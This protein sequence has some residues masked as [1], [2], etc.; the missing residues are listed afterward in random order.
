VLL[1]DDLQWA[2][3]ATLELVPILASA[4]AQER[5]LI[6]GTYRNDEIGRGH[7][8]R[9][10]R[11]DLRRARLL[12]EIVV[13]PLDQAHTTALATRVFG[14]SPGP[15]LAS[16]LYQRTEGVPL[17]VKELAGALAI[18]GRLRLSEAG[19]ELVP[20]ADL[21]IP[22]TLRD[23]VLLR[24]DGLPDPAL[25]LLHLAVVAGREFD[26]ALVAELAGSTDG[27]DTLL[28]RGLLVEVE[29]GRGAFRHA[30]TREAIYGDISWVRRRAIHR[31]MAERLQ[32]EGVAPLA[33]AQH[34]LAAKEP[35]RA[36]TALL[37][38]A[39]QACAI[40]A[41]RDAADAAQRALELWPDG[42]E[43][44]RRL[45]VLDQ[46]G[47]CAQLC[48]MLPEAARVWREVADGR[49]L[50]G[51]LQSYAEAERKLANVAE[52]QGH[53]E[54]AL[55]AREA[56]AQA[57]AASK[58]PA[59]SATERLSAAAHLRSAGRYR[60]A[61]ELLST[62]MEEAA[63]AERLDLHARI[64][65]QE[66]SVRA[67]MGQAAEGLA[68]VQSG[69]ALA[70]ELNLASAAAEIYQRLAD[71]LEHAGDYAG[72]KE[73][74]L[75]AFDFCQANAVPTTAQ[76]CVAC[77]TVVLR[78]TGEWERA[79]TLCREVLASQHSSLHARAVASC[80]L[81]TLYALRG[82]PGRAQ[83]LLLEAAS[84]GQQ[85]ELAAVELLAAWGLA[86]LDELNG[87]SGT[88]AERCRFI[89][90]RW[91]QIEDI[92]YAVPVLRWAVSFFAT[93]NAD[94]DA[95]A[96]ANA[97]ARIASATGQPE[98]LSALAHALGEIALLDG[99]PQQA[100]QQF[101]QAL[102]LLRDVAIPYC[103]ANTQWRAGIACAAANQRDAAVAHLANAYRTAR[104]L[105]ARPLATRIAQA[106]AALGEPIVEH[107]GPGAAGRFR[108][109]DL[110]RR[111]R[112]ILQ[113]VAQ[114]QTNVEIARTLVLSPRT[115]EMHVANIL[116][117]LD[118]RSRAEAVRRATELSL[119]EEYDMTSKKIL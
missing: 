12:H 118:S 58:L 38:A 105:G 81:G 87:A 101:R 27:L 69:L 112:E 117:T 110:T 18:R 6:V 98:A 19:I 73:T 53:W 71:S 15:A 50:A 99:N 46:L 21:P 20:G 96:C 14:Q 80:M 22:D 113:L 39:E 23:A 63:Q 16:T 34:W 29:P 106:L 2:D 88:V 3:N 31:Q 61:L 48:G 32:A 85:I 95:R 77:L 11:N 44:A 94:A 56:A 72:A 75:T 35:D 9:R 111:Q 100:V 51:D 89:L 108:S 42:V 33:I 7:P 47:Q 57:F 45:D 83:P 76:L 119:L 62:A 49:R 40:H 30:L 66:G 114:G 104:K 54:R 55:A 107:L 74:Y 90:R 1:L 78:Q 60:T 82:Q 115:V 13:E 41:Y 4:L 36:R 79:M 5:L 59:E 68:L 93:T 43:D 102:D 17:F 91:E 65:G 26:L 67:R 8:L 37:A 84:L 10:L 92:H 109:G 24:L 64:M 86:L 52:L 70:L 116:S 28:E 103:H 25:Q 97:L